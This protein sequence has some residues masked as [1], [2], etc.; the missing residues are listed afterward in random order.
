MDDGWRSSKVR[1]MIATDIVAFY[2]SLLSLQTRGIGE[3]VAPRLPA[4]PCLVLQP[5][6]SMLLNSPENPKIS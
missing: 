1:V 5:C 3:V 4:S 6:P 2:C